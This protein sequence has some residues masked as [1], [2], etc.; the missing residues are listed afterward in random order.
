MRF[1]LP[2]LLTT[3]LAS[4]STAQEEC[5]VPIPTWIGDGWCD[6]GWD[7]GDCCDCTCDPNARWLCGQ[8][9]PFNCLD[10][11]VN[12]CECDA[13]IPGWVGDGWCV[14]VGWR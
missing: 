14:R 11:E 3:L 5:D 9:A 7:G 2:L 8:N 13:P 4:L 6:C 12:D 1:V 10:P